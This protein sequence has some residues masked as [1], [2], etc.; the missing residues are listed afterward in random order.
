MYKRQVLLGSRSGIEGVRCYGAIKDEQAG[1]QANRYFPKSWLENDPA[2]RWML[3]QSAP[4]V[5]PYR[6]N[7][8]MC[9]TVK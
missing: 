5:V 2:V 8:S 9:V 4:L 1:F 3:L 7:A 6:P